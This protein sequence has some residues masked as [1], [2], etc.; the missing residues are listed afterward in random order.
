MNN[1]SKL[2]IGII[3]ISIL[4]LGVYFLSNNYEQ[5]NFDD[6]Y[7]LFLPWIIL[8]GL[9]MAFKQLYSWAR[10]KKTGAFVFG[11]LIQMMMPDPYVDRTI[12][13]I[14]EEKKSTE[15]EQGDS[16]DLLN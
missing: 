13:V 11:M 7:Q 15:K 14:Q 9:F 4:L 10:N 3:A 5:F 2:L 1:V 8:F 6:L 16:D 12:Q